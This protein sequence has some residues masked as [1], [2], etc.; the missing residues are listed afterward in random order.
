MTRQPFD[1][2][3]IIIPPDEWLARVRRGPLTVTG[4]NQIVQAALQNLPQSLAVV[5]QISNLARPT[6]GHIYFTLKDEQSEVRAVIWKSDAAKIQFNLEDGLEVLAHG[7]ADIFKPRGQYQ[8]YI[9]ILEPRGAGAL[10]L[11]FR[12]LCDKLRAE[13][14]EDQTY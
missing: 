11:A 14:P 6:S 7:R 8:F 4:L 9:T 2:D 13:G 5:G 12:Q 10:E 3:R 1:P